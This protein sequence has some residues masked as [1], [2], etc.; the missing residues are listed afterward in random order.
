VRRI[1]E[2]NEVGFDMEYSHFRK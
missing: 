1:L 2:E